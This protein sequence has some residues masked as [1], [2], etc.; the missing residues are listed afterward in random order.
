MNDALLAMAICLFCLLISTAEAATTQAICVWE[1]PS[2]RED[3]TALS[4]TEIKHVTIYDESGAVLAQVPPTSTESEL[5]MDVGCVYLSATD[6][7]GLESK[8]SDKVCVNEQLRPG[9]PASSIEL[10]IKF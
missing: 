8:L 9:S 10:R 4:A 7:D 1:L 3:G 5:S 2:V 6:S